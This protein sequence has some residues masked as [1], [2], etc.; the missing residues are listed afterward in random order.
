MKGDHLPDS[1]HVV[2][3]CPGSKLAEDGTPLATAFYLRRNEKYLSVEWLEYLQLH[4]KEDPVRKVASIFKEKL[5]VGSTARMAILNVGN[6]CH[7]V[8]TQT[9]L[10]IR[11]LHEPGKNDPAHAGI[12]DT[13]QDEMII[14]ELITETVDTLYP[15]P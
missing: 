6:M 13:A 8:K 5:N 14:A 1:D 2:R 4:V 3:Y 15:F 7:H 10:T 9:A 12:H 11:V